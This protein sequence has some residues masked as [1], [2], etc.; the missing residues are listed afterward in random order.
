MLPAARP[1]LDPL[2]LDGENRPA[3]SR[4]LLNLTDAGEKALAVAS[5]RAHAAQ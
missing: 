3:L 2:Y 4:S 1:A 5:L